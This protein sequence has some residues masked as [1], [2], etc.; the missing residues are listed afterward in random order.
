M[1][2]NNMKLIIKCLLIVVYLYTSLYAN[3]P[4]DISKIGPKTEKIDNNEYSKI[5]Y[6]DKN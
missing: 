6:V 4:R 3:N 2:E 1:I 5:F